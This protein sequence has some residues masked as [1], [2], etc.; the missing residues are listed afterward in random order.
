VASWYRCTIT[1]VPRRVDRDERRREIT[2]AVI[3]ITVN[4]GL[5]SATF[6]E[7]AAEAGVSVRLVQYYFGTKDQLL[8]ATQR[9]VAQRSIER[10]RRHQADAGPTPRDRIRTIMRSFVPIDDE[11]RDAML[12]YVA[13]F[14]ASLLDPALKRKEAGEVP[15][16]MHH[17]FAQHLRQARLRSGVDPDREALVLL[18]IVTGV[19][20]GVLD[21]QITT[22]DAFATIDYALDRALRA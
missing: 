4:G 7:V 22:A 17:V 20:Q 3:R 18:M 6:R 8:L 16:S 12:V 10:I 9:R 5:A 2:D 1:I 14:T 15:A 13:L 19:S 11:S 21:G